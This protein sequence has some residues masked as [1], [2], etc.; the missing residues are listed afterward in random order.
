M[1]ATAAEAHRH[2]ALAF[3]SRAVAETADRL[4]GTD[5]EAMELILHLH[6]LTTA[7]VYDLES[8]VHRPAGWSWSAF[9]AMF[10]LWIN[11]PLEPSRLAEVSG[12]SRQA[13]SALVKT[14]E[15][16]GLV[17]RSGAEHDARS[18]VLSLTPAGTDRLEQVFAEHNRREAAWAARL[19]PDERRTMIRLLAKLSDTAH[20][21]W[22]NQRF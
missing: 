22:V 9:R 14:L 17:E 11:G 16:D 5:R 13:V 21:P 4:P 10:T 3:V 19:D 2:E 18:F 8:S 15:A 1:G 20:E 12:M 7:V 6:R